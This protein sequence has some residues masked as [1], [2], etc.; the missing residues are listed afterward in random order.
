M[1][2][3]YA[4]LDRAPAGGPELG[5][6]GEPVRF[7]T[8]GS[9]VLAVGAVETPASLSAGALRARDRLVRDLAARA[10]AILPARW[11]STV[12][13]E[14]EL[15]RRLEP[16][17][18]EIARALD[19][20]RGREQMTLRVFGEGARGPLPAPE[21]EKARRSGKEYLL[22]RARALA[23]E[24]SVPEIGPL[25]GALAALVRAERVERHDGSRLLASV[26]HLIERGRAEAY[27]ELVARAS[28]PF[29]LRASGPS[30]PYAF[31]PE[32]AA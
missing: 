24:R 11:G 16:R 27:L 8:L 18:D 20:V 1:I 9:L 15:A 26:Q 3:L 6:S 29:S 12:A 5:A 2:E 4:V 14:P 31:A 23:A 25:R 10:A 32:L 7:V 30:P 17:A 28:L 13:D 22:A 19:L 21:P